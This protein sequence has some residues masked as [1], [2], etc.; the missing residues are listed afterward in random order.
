MKKKYFLLFLPLCLLLGSC[1]SYYQKNIKF[2]RFFLSKKLAEA[3]QLLAKDKRAERRKTRLLYYL[4]RGIT[5]HLMGQYEA[6]NQFFE[7][8]YLT[9]ENFLSN[10]VDETLAFLVNPTITD[11][12]GE[13]HEALLIHY[14][15][16]LNFLQLGKNQEASV[17][18]RRL[19][20]K[21]N[22]L[23]DKYDT[24]TKYRRDAFIH[25]LMGLV[26]QANHD[27]NIAFIAYRNAVEIYQEDYKPLFG[28]DAP[29]QLKK[30][31]I[32][33]AYKT[34]FDDQ[35]HYYKQAFHLDYDPVK[36]TA[37]GDVI[38]LWNS[39]LG[40]VKSEWNINFVVLKGAGGMVTFANEELGLFFPFPLGSDSE[41]KQ[42]LSDL[43]LIRVAF[44][45][46][47]ARPLLY[48]KAVVYANGHGYPLEV[49]EDINAISFQILHQRMLLEFSK[50]LLR[51]ALKKVAEYQIRKQ[52]DILGSILGIVNFAT[53]KADTRNWQ[54]IPHSIYYTRIK[55]P[56]GAHQVSFRAYASQ[57]PNAK[58]HQD[59]YVDIHPNQ[60]IFHTVSSLVYASN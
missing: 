4:N 30:D 49:V 47:V 42:S 25:T 58:Q 54:T 56:E 2:H 9:H 45:K 55:L 39:G 8:A 13:D 59:F 20:I 23:S 41:S 32:Y 52:N 60:T 38:F 6:S 26:Y 36:E 40:P 48:D 31:L 7:Q 16:A 29:A 17:E 50:S 37:G 46:Y 15:K 14:Y 10:P 1:A 21:L 18:C 19:N 43:Q 24:A 22:Q 5:T 3:D 53:E 12:R 51:V 33:T 11:Y 44:P 57:T 27:Y 35:V 34:G 28:L